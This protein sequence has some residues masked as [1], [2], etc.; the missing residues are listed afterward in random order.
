MAWISKRRLTALK[1]EIVQLTYRVEELEERLCPCEQHDWVK[2][3]FRLKYVGSPE[4]MS[5]Y[6]YKCLVCGKGKEDIV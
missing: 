2:V 4:P 5:I 3:D 6:R 1:G